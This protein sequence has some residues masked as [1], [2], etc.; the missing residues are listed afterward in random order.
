MEICTENLPPE[1]FRDTIPSRGANFQ[2]ALVGSSSFLPEPYLRRCTGSVSGRLK[3]SLFAESVP[4]IFQADRL[5]AASQ[6]EPKLTSRLHF[7]RVS[8]FITTQGCC[9]ERRRRGVGRG[10]WYGRGPVKGQCVCPSAPPPLHRLFS[11]PQAAE[12]IGLCH[13]QQPHSS[14]TSLTMRLQIYSG[15]E[16]PA[17]F[18]CS[19]APSPLSL[20][21]PPPV[22]LFFLPPLCLF[23]DSP[24]TSLYPF[25]L[26]P[27]PPH[28]GIIPPTLFHQ[29]WARRLGRPDSREE[30]AA[31]PSACPGLAKGKKKKREEQRSS[32]ITIAINNANSTAVAAGEA[33]ERK[34]AGTGTGGSERWDCR[35]Q[36]VKY[37]Q[38]AWEGLSP[39]RVGD[40]RDPIGLQDSQRSKACC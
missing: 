3:G 9:R 1:R 33:G 2:A 32:F 12:N 27:V 21:P 17:P 20:A 31:Y 29:S 40:C 25:S 24:P 16:R 4:A 11:S 5:S 15:E 30:V 22:L 38:G 14:P 37:E 19:P 6:P 10:V 18:H 13:R 8:P 34:V 36:T 35:G 7:Q 39:G 23:H 28:W 26:S